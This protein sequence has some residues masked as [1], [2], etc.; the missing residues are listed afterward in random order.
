MTTLH[1]DQ[2][3]LQH[4]VESFPVVRSV[5]ADAGFPNSLHIK[6]DAYAPVA[7]LKS[8]DGRRVAVSGEGA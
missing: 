6:V 3:E 5:S 2:H 7:A 4:S 8:S 1:V